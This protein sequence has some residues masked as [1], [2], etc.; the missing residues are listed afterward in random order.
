MQVFGQI[1]SKFMDESRTLCYNIYIF[2]FI[3]M[4][5]CIYTHVYLYNIARVLQ[6]YII[7]CIILC[8]LSLNKYYACRCDF[9]SI[10]YAIIVYA[11]YYN[12][13]T[14]MSIILVLYTVNNT[15]YIT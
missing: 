14:S 10:M 6:L 15:K 4:H 11:A 13:C 9:C 7:S 8:I 5:I 1:L 3:D 12:R 2:H